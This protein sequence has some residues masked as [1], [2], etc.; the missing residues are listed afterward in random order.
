MQYIFFFD[1]CIFTRLF[2]IEFNLIELI[3]ASFQGNICLLY[4]VAEI[5]AVLK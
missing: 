1:Y 3:S 5:L 4:L 2:K